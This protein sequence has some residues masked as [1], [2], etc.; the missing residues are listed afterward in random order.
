MEYI[1]NGDLA[2]YIPTISTEDEVR[3][4]ST[5]LLYGL[6]IMHVEGFAHRDLKP[7]VCPNNPSRIIHNSRLL[8]IFCS[9]HK[10]HLCCPKAA[11]FREMV[12][13]DW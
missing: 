10:E 13:Q 8:T 11:T 4:I 3:Q 1:E 6:K 5:D 9:F 12:G 2:R 7:Q